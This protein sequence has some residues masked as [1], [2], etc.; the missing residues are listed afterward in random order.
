ACKKDF[1]CGL[2]GGNFYFDRSFVIQSSFP[3]NGLGLSRRHRDYF[4]A[5]QPA[6]P[7]SKNKIPVQFFDPQTFLTNVR[8]DY[9]G[10]CFASLVL[11]VLFGLGLAAV[12]VDLPG[13]L[14]AL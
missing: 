12:V 13:F 2:F 9:T 3:K 8:V 5:A 4:R 10:I 7:A 14:S 1:Y 6:Q 11:A